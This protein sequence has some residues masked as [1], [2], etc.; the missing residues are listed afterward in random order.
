MSMSEHEET[1]PDAMARAVETLREVWGYPDFRPGQRDVVEAAVAG[2]DVLGVLP[3]GGGKSICF[4]VPALIDD[5]LTLVVSP[6]IALMEDQVAALRARGVEAAFINS[7]MSYRQIDQAWT[8]AEFGRY[9]L[10]YVS[11]E[12]L[13]TEQFQVRAPRLNIKRSEERRVGEERGRQWG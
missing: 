6:L 4:Q 12:R 1:I 7:G 3:T 11:P 10:L 5:G 8:D 9:R 2:R 13:A